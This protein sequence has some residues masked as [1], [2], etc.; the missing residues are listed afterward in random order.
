MRNT[1]WSI[2]YKGVLPMLQRSTR[3]R[4]RSALWIA[5]L[6]TAPL[7]GHAQVTLKPDGVWRY[8]FT[9]GANLSSGNN[10]STTLNLSGDAARVTDYDKLTVTGQVAHASNNGNTTTER[11][12]LGS[13]YNR[14]FN[15]RWFGFGSGD[16]LRDELANIDMRYSVAGGVGHHLIKRDGLT[17]DVSGGLG[18]T[19]DQFVTPRF[20]NGAVRD[21]YGRMELVLAEESNHRISQSTTFRQRLALYPNLRDSG[22]YR[23]SLDTNISVAMTRSMN[24][25]AGLTYRYNSDPGIPGLKKG[26]LAFVTGVSYRID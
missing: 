13:Q 19:N 22:D 14:D 20:V 8:L 25:T 11:Y 4:C 24:L 23:A 12:S 17:F 26:D 9:A 7:G 6:C 1:Q 3:L 15:P 21:E 16:V 2:H 10:E 18:Y 5:A